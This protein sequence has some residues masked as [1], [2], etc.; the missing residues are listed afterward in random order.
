MPGRHEADVLAVMLV[1]DRQSV[2]A[3]QFTGLRLGAIAE[4]K[5]QDIELLGRRAEQEIA[6]VA[7][8]LAGAIKTAAAAG[9]RARGDIMA[10]GQNVG[11]EF[12]R[13]DQQIL[14]LDRH[15]A[16]DA[17]HRRL[18]GDVAF[19]E[20][21]D[22][23]FL[24]AAFIVEDVMR[25]ADTLGDAAGVVDVL[26]GAAGAF[27]VGGGA[28]VV[29]LQGDADHVI[30]LGLEQGSGHRTIDAAGHGDDDTGV[31]R[32]GGEVEGI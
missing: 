26:A 28:V 2:M 32:T 9:Q 20:A 19:G 5:A 13:G 27:A 23:R 15:V 30:A 4:R 10:G 29:K 12:A 18:A 16:G 21:V 8:F 31:L 17:G 24:E 3:R 11:A 6:L 22:H 14:E 7:L 1:G 25:Y